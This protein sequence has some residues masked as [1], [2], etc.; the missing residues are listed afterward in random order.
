MKISEYINI[1]K[2]EYKA[3]VIEFEDVRN[4]FSTPNMY[5][6]TFDVN[7]VSEGEI[8]SDKFKTIIVKGSNVD[9]LG[10]YDYGTKAIIIFAEYDD[11]EDVIN[12]CMISSFFPKDK[13]AQSRFYDLLSC[14]R[15]K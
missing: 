5:G 10:K 15:N 14:Y 7:Y 4:Y 9:P 12:Y 2:K 3:K 1:L 11:N 8:D 6:K 13:L